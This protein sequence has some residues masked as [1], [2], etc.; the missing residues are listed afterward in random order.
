MSMTPLTRDHLQTL[1]IAALPPL[2]ILGVCVAVFTYVDPTSPLPWAFIAVA[3]G[4]T[5]LASCGEAVVYAYERKGDRARARAHAERVARWEAE[6]RAAD[7]RAQAD[8]RE[9]GFPCD[10]VNMRAEVNSIALPVLRSEPFA[11]PFA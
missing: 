11:N 2:L 4:V 7:A 5:V 9:L 10:Y 3:V 8:A 6:D 1:A